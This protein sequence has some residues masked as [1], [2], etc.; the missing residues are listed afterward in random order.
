MEKSK[1]WLRQA[2]KDLRHAKNS[3]KCKDYEWTCFSAQQTAE[4]AL[5]SVYNKK[6]MEAKGHSILGLLKGL[7]ELY[8]IP[9]RFYSYARILSRYYIETRYPNGFPEGAPMD[10]F[11]KEMAEEAINATEEI[12]QWCKGLLNR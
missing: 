5:K 3:L 8:K 4:K 1:D 7:E 10:Y 12:L 2:E 9:G 11:D 6:N